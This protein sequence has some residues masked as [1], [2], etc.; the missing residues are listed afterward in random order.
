M[1]ALRNTLPSSLRARLTSRAAS[2]VTF[3]GV[4]LTT[5]AA[6]CADAPSAPAQDALQPTAAPSYTML[7]SAATASVLTRV[8]PL[9][10]PVQ[11][12]AVIGSAGGT[13]TLPSTGLTLTVPAG[14]VSRATTFTV[15]APAGGGVWYDFE[16]SGAKFAQPLVITQDLR[17]A[18]MSGV[19]RSALEGAYFMDGTRNENS[20]TAKVTEVLPVAINATGTALSFRVTHFSGYMVSTGRSD[21]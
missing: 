4:A 2:F 20:G 1:S 9:S 17:S 10:R 14:A 12:S 6:A 15:S 13:L 3:G 18:N 7:S 8:T 11:A 16:P 21:F 19:A 5:F